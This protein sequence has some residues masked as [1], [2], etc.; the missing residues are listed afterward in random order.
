MNRPSWFAL[1]GASCLAIIAVLAPSASAA[2]PYF[3]SPSGSGSACTEAAPCSLS[4]A[5][6]KAN[7]GEKVVLTPGTY[8]LSTSLL[9]SKAIDLG[10]QLGAPIPVIQDSPIALVQVNETAN[11]HLHDMRLEGG[12]E[13]FFL[14][15]LAE[16]L[17]VSFT[18]SGPGHA[19]CVLA[20]AATLRNSVCWA[21]DGAAINAGVRAFA[22]SGAPSQP[23]VLRNDTVITT[24]A[25]A[26]AI[27]FEAGISGTKATM[28]ATNVIARSANHA[29]L[30]TVLLGS[31]A[32]ATI[33]LAHSNYGSVNQVG[34]GGTIT[35]A[36]SNGN[37]AGFPAFASPATGD[38]REIA[39]SPTIDAGLASPLEDTVDLD[40]RPRSQGA[41]IGAP[42][43]PDIGA[44]EF[45]SIPCPGPPPTSPS[46][47]FK[48]G[49][50]KLNKK[51]GTATLSVSVPGAGTLTLSGKG[52]KKVSLSAKGAS[53]L[54]VPI[55]ALGTARKKLVKAGKAKLSLTL[56]FAP[57]GGT[58]AS[59]GEK[60]TLV[61]KLPQ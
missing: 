40:G 2:G 13:F 22:F 57:N 56:T 4:E 59:Q 58:S 16:R 27:Q 30:E 47:K 5:V 29:D 9:I 10:G 51:K 45:A 6:S 43:V 25:T 24:A 34:T 53:V 44:Y 7:S 20:A 55:K 8:T 35:L 46:N 48:L 14:S 38:F 52:V 36:G 1:A 49:K 50:L 28:E 32:T 54:T 17:F 31:G 3:A 26:A 23:I 41:C 39:G 33:A 18:G 15:G 11:A 37:Q 42:G 60:V 12:G 61:K 19:A 21:H